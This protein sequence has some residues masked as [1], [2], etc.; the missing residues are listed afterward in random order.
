MC[1]ERS[2]QKKEGLVLREGPDKEEFLTSSHRIDSFRK[3]RS[4][5]R[6]QAKR[7]HRAF[8]D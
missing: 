8:K 4:V 2:R 6:K 7:D 5:M 1:E 3:T